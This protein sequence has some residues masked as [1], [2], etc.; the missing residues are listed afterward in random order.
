MV[1]TTR[2]S[3]EYRLHVTW[4]L[5]GLLADRQRAARLLCHFVSGR[6]R[7]LLLPRGKSSRRSQNE[8]CEHSP[9]EFEAG[10]LP[11]LQKK[12]AP[13]KCVVASPY[14]APNATISTSLPFKQETRLLPRPRFYYPPNFLGAQPRPQL[15]FHD[16]IEAEGPHQDPSKQAMSRRAFCCVSNQ[17]KVPLRRVT[18]P[19][20]ISIGGATRASSTMS[21]ILASVP[22]TVI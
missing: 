21:T 10:D 15:D 5:L 22:E 3:R 6:T 20:M 8:R 2:T 17:F 14:V 1:A 18:A 7:S 9:R 19:T 12:G 13:P 16:M 4:I 11:S